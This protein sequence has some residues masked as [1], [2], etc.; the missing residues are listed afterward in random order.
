MKIKSI[1]KI[2]QFHSEEGAILPIVAIVLIILLG[3]A[4]FAID[5]GF[6]YMRQAKLQS[7]ADAEALVCASNYLTC[8]STGDNYPLTNPY[9]FAITTTNPLACP[10]TNTQ[11]NCVSASA[12]NTWNTYFLSLFGINS[13]NLSKTA[14]AGTPII[15]DVLIIRDTIKMNGTNIMTVTG[16]SVSDGGGIS[17]T[18]SSGIDATA[19]GATITAYNSSTN[20]CGSCTP[21]VT[22][23]SLPQP[24]PPAYAP[25]A[26]PVAK[27]YASGCSL[28]SGTYA[29][30]VNLNACGTQVNMSGVYYFNGGFDNRGITLAN[31]PGAPV[32]II[33]GV[34]QPFNLSG[35]VTLN[36][37]DGSS[38]CGTVGGGM[39]IYQPLTLTNTLYTIDVAGAGNNISLTGK[40]QLPN[41]NFIFR[42]SPTSFTI[43]GSLYANSMDL[44]G[45]MTA[46]TSPDPCQNINLSS[47]KVKLLQ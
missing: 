4:A 11:K 44:K 15:A 23:S 30:P 24:I 26:P 31:Q 9:G 32:T 43:M 39:V 33:I 2:S 36:S 37:S 5:F 17:T 14:I 45:N 28:P 18:N 41:T 16:G 47:G 35:S 22:S 19:S 6:V 3:F 34:D 40:T 12:A 42:G 25:P 13:F 27:V 8:N 21:A 10:N 1:N 20:S 38:T 29:T 7:V 46:S